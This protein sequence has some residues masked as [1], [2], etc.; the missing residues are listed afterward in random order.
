MEALEG[1]LEAEEQ[2]LMAACAALDQQWGDC[3]RLLRHMREE[4]ERLAG[5]ARQLHEQERRAGQ[6]AGARA[7]AALGRLAHAY[8]QA[9]AE[10]RG[11][12]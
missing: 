12:R 1:Q 4:S 3:S 5:A 6:A 9:C 2:R 10:Q 8:D 7:A 11:T